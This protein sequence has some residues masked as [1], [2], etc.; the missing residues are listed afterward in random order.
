MYGIITTAMPALMS[1]DALTVLPKITRVVS[2]DF[3]TVVVRAPSREPQPCDVAE[4][5]DTTAV[6][7]MSKRIKTSN[8]EKT[9]SF[10]D[11]GH[12]ILSGG[13]W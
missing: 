10:G 12:A 7:S 3:D 1:S 5:R 11:K 8:N 9:A 2:V 6:T 13:D 4:T